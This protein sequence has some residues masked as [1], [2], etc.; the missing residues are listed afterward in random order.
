[1]T[2]FC[3]ALNTDYKP[4]LGSNMAFFVWNGV[5]MVV[6]KLLGRNRVMQSFGSTLPRFMVVFLTIMT[7]LPL[8]HWFGN[9]YI[10]QG[11]LCDFQE[12][13]FFVTKIA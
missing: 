13:Y 7:A 4:Q 10:K 8:A 11:L 6:E 2:F 3:K 5:I 12:G 1:M 9:P